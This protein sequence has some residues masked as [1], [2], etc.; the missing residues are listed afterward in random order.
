M[1]LIRCWMVMPDASVC[2]AAAGAAGAAG[3]EA[4]GAAADAAQ[5]KVRV[6]R[7]SASVFMG[8]LVVRS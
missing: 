3:A 6:P 5:A 7:K 1:P 2:G 4:A 8:N